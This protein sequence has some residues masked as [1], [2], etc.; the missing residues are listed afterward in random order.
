MKIDWFFNK[1]LNVRSGKI[2][3]KCHG[4]PGKFGEFVLEINVWTLLYVHSCPKL[5]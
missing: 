5:S 4:K 2:S 3:G 1:C